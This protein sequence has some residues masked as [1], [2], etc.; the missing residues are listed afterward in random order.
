ML[1]FSVV[2][3][4]LLMLLGLVFLLLNPR[5]WQGDGAALGN[6]GV[7][8]A[9]LTMLLTTYVAPH[10]LYRRSSGRWLLPLTPLFRRLAILLSPL[11]TLFGFF[12]SLTDL[13][14]NGEA[15][16]EEPTPAENIEA[17]IT[18]GRRKG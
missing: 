5:F 9:W 17:L 16:E 15:E 6:R 2:K 8:A 18:A 4:T 1:T 12:Q 14:E 3:H 10:V 11:V 13:A 7:R